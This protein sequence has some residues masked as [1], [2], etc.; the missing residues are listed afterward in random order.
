MAKGIN[1]LSAVA[2]LGADR[3]HREW[4]SAKG[5]LGLHR[6]LEKLLWAKVGVSP[7]WGSPESPAASP[8]A[9]LSC[10]GAVLPQGGGSERFSGKK[11]GSHVRSPP[12]QVKVTLSQTWQA[13]VTPCLLPFPWS[14][15]NSCITEQKPH[16]LCFS[17]IATA[18]ACETCTVTPYVCGSRKWDTHG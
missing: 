18:H 3:S 4:T 11:A 8:R 9:Q 15:S 13:K 6:P 16:L 10:R 7:R 1:L 14:G 5:E 17:A 2:L 12:W